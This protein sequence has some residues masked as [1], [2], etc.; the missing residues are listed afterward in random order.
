MKICIVAHNAYGALTGEE[1]GHIG[2]VERQAVL[3]SHWLVKRRHEVTVV[4]WGEGSDENEVVKGV[5]LA[6]LCKKEE[7]IP[8]IRFVIPRWTSLNK[9]LRGIDA[10][11]YYHNCHEHTTGQIALWCKLNKKPFIY[12]VAS[13]T[14]CRLDMI[15]K[16]T[17]RER[18]LFKYGLSHADL[19]ITQ[20]EKQ[21]RL[22]Q[23]NLSLSS[24]VI[25]MSAMPSVDYS[26]ADANSEKF[27]QKKI[28]W[29]GRICKVKRLQ[30]FI[31]VAI[32]LP[33]FGFFVVGPA[34]HR[35]VEIKNLIEQ[36]N[37]IENIYYMGA[38]KRAD[39][40]EVYKD[41][42][43]LCCTSIIE[44][45]P[46]TFLEAWSYQ[47]PVVTTFD[48][49]N[50]VK[51]NELGL[52]VSNQADLVLALKK[53]M[54]N[55]ELKEKFSRNSLA[56]FKR[57]HS[58][59]STMLKFELAF[60][61]QI[62][63]N[64]TINYFDKNSADW[65]R[66]YKEGG[67]STSHLDLQVR[68]AITKEFVK[69]ISLNARASSLDLGCGTGEAYALLSATQQYAVD[70]SEK[71][72]QQIKK[73][74][75]DVDAQVAD[76]TNLPFDS[77]KF[78]L[79]IALGVIEYIADHNQVIEEISRVLSRDGYFIMSFPNKSSLFRRL[80]YLEDFFMKPLR[81]FRCFIHKKEFIE[82]PYHNQWHEKNIDHL[83]ILY[84]LKM[85]DV[86]YCSYGFL[87]PLLANAKC[88]VRLSKWLSQ[89]IKKNS[90]LEKTLA[91]TAVV[92]IKKF[93]FTR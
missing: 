48:P 29:V 42:A 31:D 1:S 86:K 73:K 25:P 47:T 5:T 33:E 70:F 92:L 32:K 82:S 60:E 54:T 80:R 10:D 90:L 87:S 68:L 30:W 83:L 17:M 16:H 75:P 15:N 36:I 12:A 66:F 38:I 20:T 24:I 62:K 53:I 78:Q 65:D 89:K 46:N 41:A 45:F 72:I 7:G 19:L 67:I 43:I 57:Y 69:L 9:V 23:D 2:G 76:A 59:E 3:M 84:G 44:G 22:L 50:I 34:D 13:D 52:S 21:K 11:I 14:D 71:M 4:T 61:S 58:L 26:E 77:E 74:H 88:N 8:V 64:C 6:K 55:Q 18:Y 85:V 40:A 37:I 79:V 56:Y 91:H 28:I 39:M 93:N 49:D 27:Y 51:N 81:R 35:I 63:K